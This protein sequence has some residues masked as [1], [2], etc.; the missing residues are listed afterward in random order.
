[1]KT[2]G[3]DQSYNNCA[4]VILENTKILTI[5]KI[6]ASKDVDRYDQAMEIAKH[7]V[8]IC[9]KTMPDRIGI[10][11]LA[12]G[13]QRGNVTRDLAGLLFVIMVVLRNAGYKNKIE[14][15]PPKSVKL[16]ACKSGNAKKEQMYEVLPQNVKD[17]IAD[18]GYKKTTGRYDASDAYWIAMYIERAAKSILDGF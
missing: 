10:E 3:I 6:S 17:C 12:F 18:K 1:M 8:E 5:G 9:F 7:L 4:Y 15:V 2:I 11:G 14:I 16:F 13:I